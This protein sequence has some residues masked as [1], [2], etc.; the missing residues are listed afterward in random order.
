MRIL[1][2]PAPRFGNAH[3]LQPL[4]R[5]LARRRSSDLEMMREHLAHLALDGQVR[6]ERGERV[7]KHE[8]DVAAAKAVEI[9]ARQVE[10][11]APLELDRT[12]N[13]RIGRCETERGKERLTL[14]RTA[15]A[16]DAKAFA[17]RD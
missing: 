12:G 2:K 8:R 7:L 17:L 6:G 4:D 10:N 9:A 11:L 5:T 15:L 13:A 1:L 3:T 16:D 14:A